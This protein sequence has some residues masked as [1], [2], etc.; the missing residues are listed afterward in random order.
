MSL[1]DSLQGLAFFLPTLAAALGAGLIVTNRRYWHLV[2]VQRFLAFSVLGTAALIFAHVLPAALGILDRPSALVASLSVLVAAWRVP[3]SRD[4]EPDEH[5]KP[6]PSSVPALAIAA[7]AVAL[8]LVYQL[9]RV[10]LYGHELPTFIDAL[11]F[12]LPGVATFIQTGTL[13]RVDQFLPGFATAQYPNNGDFLILSTVLPWRDLALVRFSM[14]PFFAL[15]GVGTYALGVELGATRAA[16]ATFAAAGMTVPFIS[17][18]ALE[19]IPDVVTLSMFVIGVLFVMR[20]ARARRRSDLALGG[21]A[22]GISLG[23]KWYGLTAVAVAVVVWLAGWLLSRRPLRDTARD[24]GVLLGTIALGGGIWLLRNLIE[25]GNP[26]YPKAVSAFGVQ[27]FTG[28][29]NDVI[30]QY[31]YTIAH[32]LSQPS[33]LRRYIYPGFKLGLGLTGAVIFIAMVITAVRTVRNWRGQRDALTRPAILLLITAAICVVY[34]LTPGTAYGPKNVPNGGFP[35]LRWLMPAALTGLALAAWTATKLGRVGVLLGLA[36]LVGV[37][38]GIRR[39]D[40]LGRGLI[41]TS[42][43]IVALLTAAIVLGRRWAVSHSFST[44][45]RPGPLAALG[46][47]VVILLAIGIRLQQRSFDK[48]SYAPYDPVFAW[49]VTH[50]PSGHRIGISGEADLTGLAPVFPLVGPRLGNRVAYAGDEVGHSIQLARS[51]ASFREDLLRGHYDLLEIGLTV[52]G[53]TDEWA[54]A[55]G[56]RLLVSSN[57]LALYAAPTFS[58]ALSAS[59]GG[60]R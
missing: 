11:G 58:A 47:S 52:T 44:L 17:R 48:H 33:L 13:W 46:M 5:L 16:S 45:R 49:I 9:A 21:L 2:G 55:L 36:G 30:D 43:L 40:E 20:Y 23:A 22:L 6:P 18:Y 41:L 37:I 24:L 51:A 15:T 50:A 60:G 4:G 31:G 19:G 29:H 27:L 57:R 28:S 1:A 25:S 59:T 8:V 3:A 56:Y 12:H 42:G 32:Y 26:I 54:R 7:I 39:G 34:A 35:T 53:H 14:L 10:R 38:D